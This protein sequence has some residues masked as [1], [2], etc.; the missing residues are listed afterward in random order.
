MPSLRQGMHGLP[1]PSQEPLPSA[2]SCLGSVHCPNTI[3]QYSLTISDV[4]MQWPCTSYHGG[5]EAPWPP[6]R[7]LGKTL[8]L[9]SRKDT[10][11]LAA[12]RT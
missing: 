5:L 11:V 7:T 3:I 6:P 12:L 4:H 2:L 8:L 9:M 10:K 1:R